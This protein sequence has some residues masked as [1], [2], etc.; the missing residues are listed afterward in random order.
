MAIIEKYKINETT[1]KFFMAF[2][3]NADIIMRIPTMQLIKLTIEAFNIF[4]LNNSS[5]IFGNNLKTAIVII[6][7]EVIPIIININGLTLPKA[8]L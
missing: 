7:R 1:T 4:N 6:K 5:L 2:N 8:T 3:D